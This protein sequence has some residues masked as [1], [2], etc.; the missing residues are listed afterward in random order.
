MQPQ[1]KIFSAFTTIFGK[2]V[3]VGVSPQKLQLLRSE[4][5]KILKALGV[6]SDESA[7]AWVN[8]LQDQL[9]IAFKRVEDRLGAIEERLDRLERDD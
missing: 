5:D 7:K 9:D 1:D 4:I 3:N 2:I 6:I 8:K